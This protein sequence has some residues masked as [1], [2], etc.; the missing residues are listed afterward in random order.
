[1]GAS[2]GVVRGKG[3]LGDTAALIENAPAVNVGK[4]LVPWGRMVTVA[5]PPPLPLL[6]V[7]VGEREAEG[8]KGV[9]KAE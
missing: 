5:L 6:P 1:M 7:M 4:I 9:K 8:R 2:E 3:G